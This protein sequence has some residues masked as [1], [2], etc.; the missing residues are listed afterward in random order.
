MTVTARLEPASVPVE[1]GQTGQ[2]TLHLRNSGEI[3]EA[4][5]IEVLGE[6]AAWCAVEPAE[7]SLYP[8]TTGTV[9]LSP[10]PPRAPEPAA[11]SFPFAVR[12]LPTE[13]PHD[14][15]VP[16]G[17]IEVLP[18]QALEVELSPSSR[19][20]KLS[21]RYQV[22]VRNAGNAPAPVDISAT[23]PDG[24]LKFTTHPEGETL[25]PAELGHFRVK[26]RPRRIAVKGRPQNLAFQV[27]VSQDDGP[28]ETAD[29]RFEQ[30]A[31]LPRNS[32]KALAAIAAV[33]AVLAAAW[34]GLV[35]PAITTAANN[36]AGAQASQAVAAVQRQAASSSAAAA[37][38]A[39]A[40]ASA[41]AG[42][43]ATS[44]TTPPPPAI[45]T[46]DPSTAANYYKSLSLQT[47][48]G[49]TGT[50][51]FTVPAN[52]TFMLTDFVLENP[53]GDDGTIALSIGGSQVSLLA[54]E[55]FRDTDYPWVTPLEV[56]A[57]STVTVT[58][59]CHLPGT[60]PAATAPKSCSES[61]LLNGSM[62]T[63]SGN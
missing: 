15:Q 38:A 3:V 41:S 46:T 31:L 14:V 23:A 20:G 61:A 40:S 12:V 63:T 19:R 16:E 7:L 5:R 60:P 26:V 21:A 24:K 17:T 11:G 49:K 8:G 45:P 50:A 47:D 2:V 51:T 1:P 29:G 6:P 13:R 10:A 30:R 32:G 22:A 37:S 53:Q 35:K 36:A 42:A 48:P 4:Y 54:L 28:E 27:S 44:S 18:F 62:V 58:V 39:A 9:T 57:G 55:D 33:A 43:T 56:R 59:A 34:F 25:D 52:N